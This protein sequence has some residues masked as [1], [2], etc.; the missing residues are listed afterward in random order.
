MTTTQ[1]HDTI[2]MME[3]GKTLLR[4]EIRISGIGSTLSNKEFQRAKQAMKDID[5]V[6]TG[7]HEMLGSK[8]LADA[9]KRLA[10]KDA[11]NAQS[12]KDIEKRG[13]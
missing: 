5:F 11:L 8:A 13:I 9:K 3:Q 2:V 4:E 7:L 1:L 12:I 10:D 6:I